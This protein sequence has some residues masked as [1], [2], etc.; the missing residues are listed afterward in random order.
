[1][2]TGTARHSVSGAGAALAN[3]K[4]ELSISRR[5]S[6]WLTSTASQAFRKENQNIAAIFFWVV[7]CP[8]I[9][10]G[11]WTFS[12]ILENESNF[13][14]RWKIRFLDMGS[15][16]KR[17]YWSEKKFARSHQRHRGILKLRSTLINHSFLYATSFQVFIWISLLSCFE[18]EKDLHWE[19]HHAKMVVGWGCWARVPTVIG[20]FLLLRIFS[21]EYELN[22]DDVLHKHN[23]EIVCAQWKALK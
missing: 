12:N 8:N 20:R 2:A 17:S 3:L 1:M 9:Q 13:Y 7:R 16:W 22:F 15:L 23:K 21:S 10:R 4:Q 14:R 19:L 11:Q 5:H 18:K 6:V